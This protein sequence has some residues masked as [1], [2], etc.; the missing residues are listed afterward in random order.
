[1]EMQTAQL[2]KHPDEMEK[3]QENISGMS[4]SA[5]QG[6]TTI[7]SVSFA[8]VMA[9]EVIWPPSIGIQQRRRFLVVNS[10]R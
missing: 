8:R 7:A 5:Y 4:K 9:A 10:N 1:M 6:T 2:K 3:I